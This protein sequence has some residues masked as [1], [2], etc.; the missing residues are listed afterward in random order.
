LGVISV[1]AGMNITSYIESGHYD[2]FQIPYSALEREHENL[3]RV[4]GE[5]GAGVII[6]GGVGRGEPGAGLGLADRWAQ[7][8]KAS[9]D[10]L[11]E[12]GE[13]RTGFLLRFTLTHPQLSTTIVGTKSPAHLAE[14]VR[15]AQKGKLSED[16]Y[17]EAKR[18]LD[19]VGCSPIV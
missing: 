12:E 14:N 15:D 4:A 6:R 10:D 11:L 13:S 1:I 2:T 3:I 16:I 17:A 8:E 5:G 19:S 7:W 18:R 9:L